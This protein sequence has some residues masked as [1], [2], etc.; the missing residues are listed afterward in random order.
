MALTQTLPT[1]FR[2]RHFVVTVCDGAVTA[3]EF[4]RGPPPPAL[5]GNRSGDAVLMNAVRKQVAAYFARRLTHFDLPLALHG[6]PF[7]VAV[8]RAVAQLGFGQVA[9][10]AEVGR[11][12]GRPL[13]HRGVAAAMGKAPLDL[14]IPAHRV[15]GA[16][17]KVKGAAPGSMRPLL[18]AF[19]RGATA[20]SR[21]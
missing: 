19:E 5:R 1:P 7:E 16:D 6:T 15:I 18:L 14:F 20:S 2:G 21:R 10:Y 12:V 17:G 11:A 3:G 8:W 9:S 4:R 13:S